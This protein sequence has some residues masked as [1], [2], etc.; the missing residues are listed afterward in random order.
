MEQENF[1][2]SKYGISV[3]GRV[4]APLAQELNATS[5]VKGITLSKHVSAQL[6]K[7]AVY[8]NKIVEQDKELAALKS[9]IDLL[10]KQ[11]A[12]NEKKS[13]AKESELE[14]QFANERILLKRVLAKFISELSKANKDKSEQL[15]NQY[16]TIKKNEQ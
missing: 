8:E 15:I 5:Q 2:D 4:P 7:T 11:I 3:S 13:Q 6:Q 10:K 14:N 1:N 12:S 9:E 16:N